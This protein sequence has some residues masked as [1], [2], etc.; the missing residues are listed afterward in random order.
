MLRFYDFF[1]GF[2]IQI[3]WGLFLHYWP[4]GS[5]ENITF[6]LIGIGCVVI[7]F[8]LIEFVVFPVF[9][10]FPL[11]YFHHT[12]QFVSFKITIN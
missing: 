10:F 1:W 9:K 8:C 3:D 11:S 5:S 2:S 4:N 12:D 6:L 7:L